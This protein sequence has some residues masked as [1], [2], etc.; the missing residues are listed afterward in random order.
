MQLGVVF[1][2]SKADN[3][4]TILPMAKQIK[5]RINSVNI[6]HNL[7]IKDNSFDDVMMML[8]YKCLGSA[9]ISISMWA[10][11]HCVSLTFICKE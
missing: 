5:V 10:S 2:P 8:A 11:L 9:S 4:R 7:N 6:M 3:C 1:Y